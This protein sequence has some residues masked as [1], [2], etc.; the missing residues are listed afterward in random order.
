MKHIINKSQKYHDAKN[1]KLADGIFSSKDIYE[2]TCGLI[3][4]YLKKIKEENYFP[5]INIEKLQDQKDFYIILQEIKST[6]FKKI[7]PKDKTLYLSIFLSL[8]FKHKKLNKIE[9]I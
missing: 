4:F 7:S 6:H 9:K 2:T 1:G 8:E 3:L 5:N